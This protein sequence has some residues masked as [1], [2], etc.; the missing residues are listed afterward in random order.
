MLSDY[1]DRIVA[2]EASCVTLEL[3]NTRL[4]AKT[5]DLENRS[6]RSNLRIIEIP[7]KMEEADLVKFISELL[8][9]IFLE[10]IFSLSTHPQL[11]TQAWTTTNI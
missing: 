11:R 8:V 5:D 9:G 3:E 6:C 7:E 4:K 2:L 1:R 10:K